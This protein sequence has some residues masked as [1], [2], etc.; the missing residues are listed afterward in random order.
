VDATYQSNAI[1]QSAL[2]PVPV[3]PGDRI[4]GIPEHTVKFGVEYELLP[5]WFLGSDLLYASSQ[6]V[7]GDDNNR[8]PQVPEYVIVNLNTRYR[9]T[10]YLEIFAMANNVLDQDYETFGAVNRNFFTGEAERFL[11]PGAPIAGWA[12]LR[13]LLN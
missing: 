7:R 1:L 12:G 11:G 10:K 8:L 4:P 5:G 3:Q 2:G 13:M 6:F 9:V